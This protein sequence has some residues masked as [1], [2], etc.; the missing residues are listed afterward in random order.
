MNL[1]HIS[2]S[3]IFVITITD[4]TGEK[5]NRCNLNDTCL[6]YYHIPV[7]YHINLTHLYGKLKTY[8]H[9]AELLNLRNEY[10]SF[11]FCG[12]SNTTINILQSTRYI[13]LHIVDLIVI[14]SEIT[15][16]KNNGIIYVL[17]EYLQTSETYLL[18]SQFPSIIFP[19]LY[20]LKLE[21]LGNLTEE[22]F[23]RSFHTNKENDIA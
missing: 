14:S 10:E 4:L 21:F 11:N 18:E 23:F 2:S 9:S 7:H 16:I 19:G 12:V 22:N 17:K 5:L 15:L 6:P 8:S 20:T 13:K 3:L 1:A